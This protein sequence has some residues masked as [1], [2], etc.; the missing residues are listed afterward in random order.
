MTGGPDSNQGGPVVANRGPKIGVGVFSEKIGKVV[1][2]LEHPPLALDRC[3]GVPHI[4]GEC[5]FGQHLDKGNDILDRV[6]VGAIE[7]AGF[8]RG[9]F[10]L[11]AE[12][13]E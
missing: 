7:D 10:P 5:S 1:E 3:L 9:G 13:S 6:D 11:V 12:L 2:A 4:L 8:A